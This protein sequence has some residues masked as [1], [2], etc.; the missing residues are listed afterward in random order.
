MKRVSTMKRVSIL[1]PLM[2]SVLPSSFAVLPQMVGEPVGNDGASF[3][4]FIKAV[5]PD[6]NG[7]IVLTV[8]ALDGKDP[9]GFELV[10]G[11]K[12][13]T[14]AATLAR[15]PKEV[16][17]RFPAQGAGANLDP[18]LV[19]AGKKMRFGRVTIRSVGAP[20]EAFVRGVARTLKVKMPRHQSSEAGFSAV[21]FG[22]PSK[23]QTEAIV[24]KL[25]SGAMDQ[26]VFASVLCQ[27]DIPNRSVQ[28][29]E[30]YPKERKWRE[31]LVLVLTRPTLEQPSGIDRKAGQPDGRTNLAETPPEGSRK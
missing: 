13:E 25:T 10:I 3:F 8:T 30:E 20:T 14:G 5:S 7:D 18:A 21:S 26:R 24:L 1:M 15:A 23:L 28:L 6:A 4:F 22:N 27:I 17:E 19:E 2:L 16:T 29:Q 31:G 11:Q 9:V 12:W